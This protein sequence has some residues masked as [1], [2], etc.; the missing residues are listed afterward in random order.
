MKTR[1]ENKKQKL[2]SD[3]D[4]QKEN[5]ILFKKFLSEKE[6]QLKRRNGIPELDEA[7]YKTLYQYLQYLKNIDLWFKKPLKDV[8]R[9]DIER[10]Y[11]GLE[12]GRIKTQKGTRFED[13]KSYY[14]KC[15]KSRLFQLAGDK[16]TIARDVIQSVYSPNGG[17]DVRFIREADFRKVVEVMHKPEHKLLAWLAF[18][19]GEN[20]FSLLALRKKNFLRQM[21]E[22]TR[23][24]EYLIQLSG[25]RIK[26]SRKQRGEL[27][28]FSETVFF[29]DL[30][31]PKVEDDGLLFP[32]GYRQAVK[33]LDRAVSVSKV[34]CEPNGEKVTWKDLRSSMA[35]W[36]LMKNWSL[37]EINR[38]LGHTPSSRTIDKYVN[39]LSMDTQTAKKKVFDSD[40]NKVKEELEQVKHS[41]KLQEMRYKNELDRVQKEN[42]AIKEE[43][44]QLRE[45]AEKLGNLKGMLDRL[46]RLAK[47]KKK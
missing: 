30:V 9:K 23:E 6:I 27:T 41:E 11:D 24:A 43:V 12:D 28:N 46:E 38:R 10:V 16:D 35:C 15:F 21:N 25:D 26:R 34:T 8:T 31:L 22:V 44:A 5:S 7:C 2:L 33:V 3:P 17:G 40:I 19:L 14:N 42:D 18:D 45:Y 4:L 32:Y 47:E 39:Y 20:I 29:L 37:L 36:C 1:Y 13:R